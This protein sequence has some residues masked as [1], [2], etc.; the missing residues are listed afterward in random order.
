MQGPAPLRM[1]EEYDISSMGAKRHT[2]QIQIVPVRQSMSWCLEN[3][4]R[5]SSR[6]FILGGKLTDHVA[7]RPWRGEGRPHNYNILGGGG[8][9]GG[10]VSWVS[11]GGKLSC[12]GG[13][14]GG[15][16]ELLLHSPP[17]PPPQMKP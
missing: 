9:G 4:A 2:P 5:V 8:G 6:N 3:N 11:L 13:G 12:L 7:L 14:G 16:G 1:E 15:G 10:G 17:P